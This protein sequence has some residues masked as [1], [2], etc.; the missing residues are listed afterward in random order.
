[1]EQRRGQFGADCTPLQEPLAPGLKDDE[2][3]NRGQNVEITDDGEDESPGMTLFE[4]KRG[5]RSAKDRAHCRRHQKKAK[6]VRRVLLP[7]QVA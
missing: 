2:R 5:E 6:I 7:E 3:Q 4:K 1:L